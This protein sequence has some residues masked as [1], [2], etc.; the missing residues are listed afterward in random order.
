MEK[1]NFLT[2]GQSEE[3]ALIFTCDLV[4]KLYLNSLKKDHIE[5]INLRCFDANQAQAIDKL[6]WQIPENLFIPHK[7]INDKKSKECKVEI[8]YPGTRAIKNYDFLINL[9]PQ[10]PSNYRDFRETYQI[11]IKDDS[12]L[13]EKARIS[14]KKCLKDGIKPNYI[15]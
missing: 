15:D 5:L 2:A 3:S 8:S 10:L 6:L 7:L 11:V 9:N 14:Y 13:Q 12:S 4:G 1:V